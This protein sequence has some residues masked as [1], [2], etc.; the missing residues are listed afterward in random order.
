ML[1]VEAV[2]VELGARLE[3][4]EREARLYLHMAERPAVTLSEIVSLLGVD[5]LEAESTV[6]ALIQR[7]MAIQK[8]GDEDTFEA[9]HPRFA[10]TNLFKTLEARLTADLRARRVTVDRVALMLIPGYE[11]ARRAKA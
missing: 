11:T 2:I 4:P 8:P 10:L 5:H 7:G 3:L 9:V 6:R 1:D